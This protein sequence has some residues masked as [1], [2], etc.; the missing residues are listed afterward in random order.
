MKVA[1][2]GAGPRGLLITSHLIHHFPKSSAKT[3]QIQIFDPYPIGGRVWRTTQSKLLI[4]NTIAQ[5]MTMFD[6]Q[7]FNGPNLYQW[8]KGQAVPFIDGQNYLNKND[9]LEIV[10][11]L[12]PNDYTPRCI[13]GVY[14]QWFY[15][16]ITTNLPK[17]A[18]KVV[19]NLGQQANDPIVISSPLRI[20]RSKTI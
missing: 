5:Q 2:I 15:H 10:H 12:K 16:Q 17:D 3:L 4:M 18:D 19:M 7:S 6:T 1:I 11:D 9:F 14:L 8:A 20:M 13:F